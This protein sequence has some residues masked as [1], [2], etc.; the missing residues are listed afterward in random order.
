ME[1]RSGVRPAILLYSDTF[2]NP[3][4]T[5]RKPRV[6]IKLLESRRSCPRGLSVFF[7]SVVVEMLTRAD[8]SVR[9]PGAVGASFVEH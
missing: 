8:R 6:E 2:H 9:P 4:T 5:Q 1:R 3:L 7:R